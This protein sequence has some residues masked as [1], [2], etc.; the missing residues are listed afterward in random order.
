MRLST[1]VV[2]LFLVLKRNVLHP[3][4]LNPTFLTFSLLRCFL[5]VYNFVPFYEL[6]ACNRLHSLG[7]FFFFNGRL[8]SYRILCS[9]S[10]FIL[11]TRVPREGTSLP[12]YEGTKG[13]RDPDPIS[14]TNLRKIHA[15]RNTSAQC[16]TQDIQTFIYTLARVCGSWKGTRFEKH[17]HH[18]S[19]MTICFV[20][21]SLALYNG[22]YDSLL[23]GIKFSFIGTDPSF[24]SLTSVEILNVYKG[25]NYFSIAYLSLNNPL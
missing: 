24:P 15:S 14:R 8:F 12:W 25:I 2:V 13:G 11:G 22:N 21:V 10:W 4:R 17:H 16:S 7:F 3:S 6:N 23:F 5:T 9:N 18:Q 20:H 19:F 1:V